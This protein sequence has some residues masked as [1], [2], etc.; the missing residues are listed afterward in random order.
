MRVQRLAKTFALLKP[1]FFSCA[2]DFEV[3]R[4]MRSLLQIIHVIKLRRADLIG[5]N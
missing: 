2:L 3:P 4:E 1:V 5:F